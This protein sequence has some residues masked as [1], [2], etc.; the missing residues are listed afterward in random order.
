MNN[1]N[2]N[3]VEMESIKPMQYCEVFRFTNSGDKV[4]GIV[5]NPR[6]IKTKHGDCKV[7]DIDN[8]E[9]KYS[10][11]LSTTLLPIFDKEGYYVNITFLGYEYNKRTGNNFKKFKILVSDERVVDDEETPF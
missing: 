8:L 11:F 7:V 5:C 2:W 10:L 3:L 1:K 9:D 6:I 4:E